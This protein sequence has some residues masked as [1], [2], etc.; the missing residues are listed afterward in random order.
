M[1]FVHP[2][3]VGSDGTP[4]YTADMFRRTTNV[5]QSPADRSV[6][7]SSTAIAGIRNEL[8]GPSC[9]YDSSTQSVIIS[10]HS[11]IMY[12][13]NG[14]SPYTYYVN[15]ETVKIPDPTGRYKIAIEVVDPT[16]GSGSNLQPSAQAVAKDGNVPDSNIHG[17]I[18]ATFVN[19]V[20]DDIV[21]R[22]LSGTVIQTNTLAQL[23][24]IKTTNGQRARVSSTQE[25]YI[26]SGGSWLLTKGDLLEATFK[27]QN[28]NNFVMATTS[29]LLV[30]RVQHLIYV[31]LS[32]FRCKVGLPNGFN[33]YQPAS[34]VRPSR[35]ISLGGC[36]T[37]FTDLAYGKSLSWFPSGEINVGP[38]L[39]AN[40]IVHIS[41]RVIPYPSDIVFR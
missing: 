8:D 39:G 19:G 4:A 3:T 15:G 22:L 40:D 35:N 5:W 24:T 33:V 17:I 29:Q 34:G 18:L 41:P 32:H 7:F 10:S 1:L 16:S 31:N 12:P 26:Y 20:I 30:D 25:E 38:N 27:T 13:F 2:L 28:G 23:Q 36:A 14:G 6:S 21:P 37:V 11:G 9:R